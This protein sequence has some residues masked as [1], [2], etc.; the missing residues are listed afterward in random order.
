[1]ISRDPKTS[2]A[3][4]AARPIIAVWLAG[5]TPNARGAIWMLGSALAF[6]LM[7]TLV[8]FMGADYSA[9]VQTFYR[10]VA[11]VLVLSLES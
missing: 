5:L 4:S 10:Q 2:P 1:M 9:S 11:A 8:K 3:P 7:T 6:T